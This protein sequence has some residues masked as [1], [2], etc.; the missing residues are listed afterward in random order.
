MADE[1]GD[2]SGGRDDAPGD[3]HVEGLAKRFGKTEV[4][5]RVDLDV[6]AGSIFGFLGVNG[7]G[8]TTLIRLLLG[9]IRSDGGRCRVAGLDPA[10]DAIQ[11]RRDI[12]YMA[13]NQTMYGWMRVGRLIDWVANFYPTWDYAYAGELRE[14][15]KLDAGQR[16]G[17]LSKGQ[18][19][20]L[21]L[22]LALAHRPRLVILDDPTLGLDPIARRDFL[23]D[24]I[25]HLQ[26]A[27]VTVFFSSHLLYEIEPICDHVAILHEGRIVKAAS[28][29]ALR[30][31]VKRVVIEPKEGAAVGEVP[32]LLDVDAR[33]GRWAVTVEDAVAGRAAIAAMSRCEPRVVDLNLDEIFEAY[34]IGRREVADA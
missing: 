12:G 21:A 6:P 22:L 32:G 19:S 20:R 1:P 33:N 25:G 28:V 10:K 24:V 9:L 11:I 14:Q 13:E 16:V 30:D 18:T 26:S 17:N 31:S 34:V 27:G 8:K 3:I 23:R 4:L 2:T 29:D 7:A 5:R 15:M